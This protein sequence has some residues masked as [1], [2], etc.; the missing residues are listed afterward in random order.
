MLLTC[1][2]PRVL[3]LALFFRLYPLAPP[4]LLLAYRHFQMRKNCDLS[5]CPSTKVAFPHCDRTANRP[6]EIAL[7]QLPSRPTPSGPKLK[8]TI[9]W[10]SVEAGEESCGC[11]RE[12]G[13]QRPERLDAGLEVACDLAFISILMRTKA[14]SCPDHERL[15]NMFLSVDRLATITGQA[16]TIVTK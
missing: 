2:E 13:I 11:R 16:I 14:P 15:H 1:R 9:P 12:Q 8:M 3:M 4:C 6:P 7:P 10:E 5:G